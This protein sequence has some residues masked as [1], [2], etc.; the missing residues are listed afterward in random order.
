MSTSPWD[1]VRRIADEIEV[2]VHLAGM[3]ARDRWKELQPRLAKLDLQF[4]EVGQRA[5]A[6][7]E[8]EARAIG[9]ELKRLRDEIFG[10][11]R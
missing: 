6:V 10:P 2:K 3:D 9:V 1:D 8:K 4:N 11:A 5:N 7:I